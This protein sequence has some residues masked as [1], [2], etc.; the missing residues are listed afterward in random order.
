MTTAMRCDE[1]QG[2]MAARV[3]TEER[4]YLYTLSGLHGVGLV[5]ITVW[6]CGT[7][8]E[9]SPEVPRMGELHRLIAR[10]L[11]QQPHLL[12][13]DEVR[14]LRKQ[15]GFAA[16]EFATLLGVDRTHLSRVENEHT[17]TLGETSDRL[18]RA[19]VTIAMGGEA[20]RQ[21]LLT[22]ARKLVKPRRRSAHPCIFALSHNH[23]KVAA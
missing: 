22:L 15:A 21:S 7:C 18:V 8:G 5:G 23:W 2:T 4:P 12:R 13:G 20:D 17:P 19:L 16:G 11:I 3:A 10:T 14:F 1:C 6:T 9:Q